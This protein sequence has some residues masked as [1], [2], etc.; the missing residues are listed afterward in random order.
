MAGGTAE[1]CGICLREYTPTQPPYPLSC[2]HCVH[3]ACMM[4]VCL[5]QRRGC[6]SCPYCRARLGPGRRAAPP[7][8]SVEQMP[9]WRRQKLEPWKFF[10]P[11]MGKLVL[12]MLLRGRG[13]D[14]PRTLRE[15]YQK[16]CEQRACIRKYQ[17]K[18]R[19]ELY[20]K[21]KGS[22]LQV[23]NRHMFTQRIVEVEEKRL[24][25]M[26]SR[27][28]VKCQRSKRCIE[29]FAERPL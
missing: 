12:R 20:A 17:S 6:P 15:W 1:E 28:L 3:A 18:C 9:F 13:Q 24:Y 7:R 27:F 4:E 23:L 21:A 16:T 11:K 19:N 10:R 5:A 8:R 29:F 22:V 26:H 25:A 2:G 14:A